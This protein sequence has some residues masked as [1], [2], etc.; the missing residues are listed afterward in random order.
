[1]AGRWKLILG[2][3]IFSGSTVDG[4]EFQATT[5][6]ARKPNITNGKKYQPQL[7]SWISEPSKVCYCWWKKSCTSWYGRYPIICKVLYIPGGC[8]GFEPSTVVSGNVSK[9]Q[10]LTL[11]QV[12]LWGLG[13]WRAEGQN[14]ASCG[15]SSVVLEDVLV[16]FGGTSWDE[17]HDY[18]V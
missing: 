9:F 15:K 5:W 4:S 1:M 10:I 13:G 7:V 2:P 18:Q 16:C 14:G 6:E 11:F 3:A 17:A 8:L 12:G